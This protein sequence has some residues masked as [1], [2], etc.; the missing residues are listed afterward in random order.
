MKET[1]FLIALYAALFLVLFWLWGIF[2]QSIEM[3]LESN[4]QYIRSA[5]TRV[6]DREP[7]LLI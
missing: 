5:C 6:L 2:S 3:E 1:L 7:S 4:V